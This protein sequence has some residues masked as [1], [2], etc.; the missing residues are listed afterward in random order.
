MIGAFKFHTSEWLTGGLHFVIVAIAFATEDPEALRYAL[1]AMAVVSFFA[2][3]AS[4]RR[5]RTIHDL[6][7]SRIA[8]AAQGY[9]E[10]FGR[11]EL[12]GG[13]SIVSKLSGTPCCW[14]RYYTERRDSNDKWQYVDSGSSNEHFLLVDASGE[15]VISPDGAEVLTERKRTWTQ[16][17]Y[18]QTEWTLMLKGVLYALGEF[19]T[20][21][22]AISELDER[23]DVSAMLKNW[24]KDKAWLLERF[25]LNRDGE[26]DLREWEL[27]R[28]EAQR[29]VRQRHSEGR[30]A[31][32]EGVH[33]LRK[34]RDGRL[35][36]LADAL[37]E[38]LGRRF[39][40]WSWLHL[41]LFFGCGTVSLL[42]FL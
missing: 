25:D 6:P 27:A 20:V 10:L 24:K 28:L 1:A 21:S 26:I 18:R 16:G 34:P 35:F 4:Y 30:A 5:Y 2:W 12:L 31:V 42:L 13:Q 38:K 37:P 32:T 17:D 22:G 33:L 8:S 23:A 29:E 14:F 39:A 11:S 19:S 36:L 7:T 40:L 15:C 9:V 41:I 3:I